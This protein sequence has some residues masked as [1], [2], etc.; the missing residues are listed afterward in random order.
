[1]SAA[2]KPNRTAH[3]VCI[4]LLIA[5]R[6]E[7]TA[8]SIRVGLEEELVALL[9]TRSL[10]DEGAKTYNEVEGF[11]IEIKRALK[12]G[13]VK[14]RKL[15]ELKAIQGLPANLLPVKTK[16]ELD[17]TG[18]KY[19]ANNEPAIFKLIADLIETKPSK[20]AVTVTRVD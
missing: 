9:D 18:V 17:E 7:A 12:R 8:N 6:E 2:L 4:D 20:V 13:L 15:A 3:D 11:K 5:K 16:E 14:G 19:L 10:D 1:M